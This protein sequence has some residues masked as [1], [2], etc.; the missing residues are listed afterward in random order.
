MQTYKI[1]MNNIDSGTVKAS[2][3]NTFLVKYYPTFNYKINHG[4]KEV[5]MNVDVLDLIKQSFVK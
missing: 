5:R 1:F 4:K 3:I 2:D